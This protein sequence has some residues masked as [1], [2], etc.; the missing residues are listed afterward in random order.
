MFDAYGWTGDGLN[1]SIFSSSSNERMT[2]FSTALLLRLQAV[3]LVAKEAQ[4][5]GTVFSTVL[6][7]KKYVKVNSKSNSSSY[8]Y[9]FSTYT[10][11]TVTVVLVVWKAKK[12][13]V[14]WISS[15]CSCCWASSSVPSRW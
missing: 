2:G 1:R 3:T 13:A 15:S 5:D 7:P 14:G 9:I 6:R 10:V 4:V 8:S 12:R 11:T